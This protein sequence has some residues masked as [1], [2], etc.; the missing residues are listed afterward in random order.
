MYYFI[1]I[2]V[3]DVWCV[4]DKVRKYRGVTLAHSKQYG[5]QGA[6]EMVVVRYYCLFLFFNYIKYEIRAH[7][8]VYN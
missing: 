7:K 8:N 2:R 3:V 6:N 5:T 4:A 1:I